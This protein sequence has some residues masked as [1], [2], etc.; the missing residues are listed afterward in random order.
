M[1]QFAASLA[2]AFRRMR[3]KNIENFGKLS[4]SVKEMND[5]ELMKLDWEL[6]IVDMFIITY[7]CRLSLPDEKI[8]NET[9]NTFHKFIYDDFSKIGKLLP[10]FCT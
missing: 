9:L 4:E 7:C 2:G 10:E 8:C 6:S 3:K 1:E 5:E